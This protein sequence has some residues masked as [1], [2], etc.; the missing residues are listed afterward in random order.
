[1]ADAGDG[2]PAGG[3]K[4]AGDGKPAGVGIRKGWRR[5]RSVRQFLPGPLKKRFGAATGPIEDDL[6]ESNL[7]GET[8]AAQ[9]AASP[10]KGND[11]GVR[12]PC[13]VA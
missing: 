8:A 11:A 13:N 7:S 9:D 6:V 10:G 5:G 12:V 1:V 3:R 2:K 4:P